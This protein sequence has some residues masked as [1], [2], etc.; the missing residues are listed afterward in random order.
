MKRYI[1]EDGTPFVLELI[2][3][4][5]GIVVSRLVHVEVAS[6]VVRRVRAGDVSSEVMESLLDALA[7]EFSARFEVIEL[8]GAVMNPRSAVPACGLIR[9]TAV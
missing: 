5:A 2:D 3:G 7:G 9:P 8:G 6:A 1:Q 4:E